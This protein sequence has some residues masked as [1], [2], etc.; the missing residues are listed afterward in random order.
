MNSMGVVPGVQADHGLLAQRGDV[1]VRGSPVGH[2]GVIERRLEELVLEHQS[3]VV[4]E[5]RVD[6]PER[7]AEA[8][9]PSTH[10]VLAGVVGSLGE[11][12][13]QVARTCGVHDV[14][15]LEVMVDR[16]PP[17][18]L[19]VV[20][21]RSEL[22]VLVLERVRVDR[23]QRDT[24]V[25]GVGAQACEVVDLLERIARGALGGPHPE[26]RARVAEGPGGQLDALLL[27]G[28][29][30]V[31]IENAHVASLST[32]ADSWLLR[33]KEL[34]A[35]AAGRST[36]ARIAAESSG[37]IQAST[38]DCEAA[39]VLVTEWLLESDA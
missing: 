22:V 11:P 38:Q 30:Y 3:L 36:R 7:V 27:E 37:S 1:R 28:G 33:L 8:I 39:A 29:Q 17:N 35:G 15:A 12:D 10:V 32:A 18:A 20:G 23:A 13:L 9:L 25:F 31:G 16:L 24:E 34:L 26:P 5:S 6:L 2:I 14:D 4:A 21:E 19:V